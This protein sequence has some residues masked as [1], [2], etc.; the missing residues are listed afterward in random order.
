MLT[1]NYVHSGTRFPACIIAPS[2]AREGA[3]LP[4]HTLWWNVDTGQQVC[5]GWLL[6][7]GIVQMA[8]CRLVVQQN[9]VGCAGQAVRMVRQTDPRPP[10]QRGT[11]AA[12]STLGL[13]SAETCC[14]S[15][16]CVSTHTVVCVSRRCCQRVAGKGEGAEAS[17]FLRFVERW[18]SGRVR[19]SGTETG[20]IVLGRSRAGHPW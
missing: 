12:A 1:N 3:T 17:A 19:F 4:P 20:C 18:W 9:A 5:E 8:T 10:L 15:L 16:S 11:S 2:G 14:P 6:K 7:E 13:R